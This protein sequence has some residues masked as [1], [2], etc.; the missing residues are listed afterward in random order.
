M[1]L[2][3]FDSSIPRLSMQ[4][5]ARIFIKQHHLIPEVINSFHDNVTRG[6]TNE[7]VIFIKQHHLSPEVINS[8]HGNVTRGTTN[9]IGLNMANAE[10]E[11]E[12]IVGKFGVTLVLHLDLCSFICCILLWWEH[13]SMVNCHCHNC[14]CIILWFEGSSKRSKTMWKECSG[15]KNFDYFNNICHI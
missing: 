2:R 9:E 8:F 14:C 4:S 5:T 3:R 13:P 10:V 12:S 1:L 6:T 7:I 11:A 15:N